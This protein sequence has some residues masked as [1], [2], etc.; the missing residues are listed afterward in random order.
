MEIGCKCRHLDARE[1]VITAWIG[2]DRWYVRWEDGT[3]E[4]IVSGFLEFVP[5]AMAAKP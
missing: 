1:G 3:E 2:Q 4:E 5:D